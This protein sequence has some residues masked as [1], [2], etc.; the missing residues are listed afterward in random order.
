MLVSEKRGKY[1][2]GQFPVTRIPAVEHP[3]LPSEAA[4][5]A[6]RAEVCS[7]APS[8]EAVRWHHRSGNAWAAVQVLHQS[9][10]HD[11][12]AGLAQLLVWCDAQGSMTTIDCWALG[13]E[14]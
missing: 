1:E 9:G 2:G 10:D 13:G 8:G 4:V 5:S 12:A 14:S 3:P 11:D 6:L 7:S